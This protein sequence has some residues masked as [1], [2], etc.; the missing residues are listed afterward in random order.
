MFIVQGV[1][2]RSQQGKEYRVDLG[3][4]IAVC[5]CPWIPTEF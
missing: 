1:I 4:L 3:A 5:S 2:P